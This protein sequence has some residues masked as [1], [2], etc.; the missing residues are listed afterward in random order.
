[1]D[2]QDLKSY[3]D[4]NFATKR[5]LQEFRGVV[6]ARFTHL[7]GKIDAGLNEARVYNEDTKCQIG[8]LFEEMK[9][10]FHVVLEA[11]E[12]LPH[13]VANHESRIQRLEDEVTVLKPAPIRR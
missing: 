13:R 6:E 4:Q 9:H 10:Q 1:M 3:L 12:P 5:E 8:V 2:T 11:L 7:E